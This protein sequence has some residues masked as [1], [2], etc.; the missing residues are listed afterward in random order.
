MDGVR[1]DKW[2]E[3]MPRREAVGRLWSEVDKCART[4][5]RRSVRV[6]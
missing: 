6:Y 3:A 5:G 1:K 4:Y 2:R